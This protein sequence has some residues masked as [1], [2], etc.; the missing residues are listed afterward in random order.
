MY[1]VS[2][3]PQWTIRNR[4]AGAQLPP[5]LVPLLVA[6]ADSGN[7]AQVCRATG[8]S[9]RHA[10]A[11][12]REGETVMGAPLV[13]M[14]RGRG[15]R[16][17]ELGSTV[18]WADRRVQARLTPLLASLSS[19]LEAA[20]ERV[21]TPEPNSLRIQASH[22]FAIQTLHEALNVAG[23]AHEIRYGSSFDAVAALAVGGCDLAGFHVPVGRFE[24]PMARAYGRWLKPAEHVLILVAHRRVGLMVARGNPHGV[25]GLAD[26]AR[27]ELRFINRQVGSG[28]RQI[29]ELQ[30]RAAGIESRTI[31]GYEQCEFTHAAV[32]A[33][34]ASAM[35]DVGY[36]VETPARRFGLDFLPHLSERYFFACRRDALGSPGVRAVIDRLQA[37]PTRAAIDALAGYSSQD[38]GRHFDLDEAFATPTP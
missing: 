24:A 5:R 19:E 33:Y 31:N 16:L 8:V 28:T 6:L 32:A 11:L 4:E 18:V 7:L 21:R 12:L 3:A 26:L 2:I 15:S 36:G 10:W 17:T 20:I 27:P 14:T 23:F 1:E 9:Y 35:A 30:L 34:V 13:Q 37:A 38:A 29:L 25:R 22:G